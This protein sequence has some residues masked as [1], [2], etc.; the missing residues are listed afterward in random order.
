MS[1]QTPHRPS[2][3][4]L[5]SYI[6]RASHLLLPT[7]P[8]LSTTLLSTSPAAQSAPGIS[9]V[10][11]SCT[12]ILIP[13]WNA[14]VRTLPRGKEGRREATAAGTAKATVV[15]W[16]CGTCGGENHA[17]VGKPKI[18]RRRGKEGGDG[19]RAK[20]VEVGGEKKM[21]R[22]GN[23]GSKARAKKR[24]GGTL[25]DALAKQRKGNGSGGAGDSGGGFGLDLMDLMKT[26]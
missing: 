24:K 20:K 16:E 15:V 5:T 9:N 25:A 18:K 21:D 26:G 19:G 3:S 22:G 14:H 23:Q 4:G 6:L 10:C 13:G 8:S 12:A 1:T 11:Q 2:S 17:E 7:A